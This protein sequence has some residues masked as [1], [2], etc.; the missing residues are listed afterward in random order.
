ME[1]PFM[2]M[3]ATELLETGRG[4]WAKGEI[5]TYELCLRELQ[6]RSTNE[7][8]YCL[9][10]LLALAASRGGSEHHGR[11]ES[12]VCPV[13]GSERKWGSTICWTCETQTP[14]ESCPSAGRQ[15]SGGPTA[16]WATNREAS[17]SEPHAGDSAGSCPKCNGD[18]LVLE[19]RL[20]DKGVWGIAGC[21]NCFEV[22]RVGNF[23]KSEP[24]YRVGHPTKC[25]DCGEAT[26]IVE[27]H[28]VLQSE[29]AV[30]W[31]K[32]CESEIQ[33]GSPPDWY[34]SNSSSSASASTGFDWTTV[35]G[36]SPDAPPEEIDM[37]Y[38]QFCLKFHPDKAS[39]MGTEM[40]RELAEQFQR[41]IN[42][43]Y[44]DAKSQR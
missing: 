3:S 2:R 25:P 23:S 16:E 29:W 1:R 37:A 24:W 32:N 17:L 9:S 20:G 26:P 33:L 10:E 12:R 38:K 28:Q 44:A 31:C 42:L 43:A 40:V 8:A 19:T 6:L 14:Y 22:E 39:G 35:L 27:V 15:P 18:L 13:C 11:R 4:A 34:Q 5:E 30:V 21:V 41:L 7:A 36:V